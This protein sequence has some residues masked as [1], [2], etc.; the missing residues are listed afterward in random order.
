MTV[1]HRSSTSSWDLRTVLKKLFVWLAVGEAVLFI[2]RQPYRPV[3]VVGESMLP[4]LHNLQLVIAK[5]LDYGPHR[6][7]V[8]V[9]DW[10]NEIIVKRVAGLAHDKGLP[11]MEPWMR[12]P[13][14]QVYVLGDNPSKSA[15]SRLFGPLDERDVKMVVVYPPMAKLSL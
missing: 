4:T 6:G 7:D 2:A 3:L 13:N 5:P 9:C 12:V 15:D 11:G 8:V 14:G 10:A 1:Y